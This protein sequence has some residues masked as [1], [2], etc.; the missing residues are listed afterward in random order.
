[1]LTLYALT[2]CVGVAVVS[3]SPFDQ[4][5]CPY[6]SCNQVKEGVLNVHIVPHTHDDVG[7]LKTVDQ[8]YYGSRNNIQK[9]GVQYILDSVVKE[10]WE[11]PKRR[12]IYVET[13]FFWKWWNKQKDATQQK[14]K[15]LVKE[16]RLQFIG[17]AWSMNDEATTH[18]QS[19]I[20]QFTWGLRKL[21]DTF[22]QCGIPT[23]GW[24]ID[25]L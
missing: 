25:P 22:G 7:W 13:A 11:D 5:Q 10:L 6:D 23:V 9:A 16:G 20:D 24:Q 21:K 1:M 18:Y 2:L 17:G 15:T 14:V 4:R 8:Y 12:F 19:T 3:A